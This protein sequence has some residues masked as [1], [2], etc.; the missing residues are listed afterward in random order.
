MP[1]MTSS[2][3][4]GRV[5]KDTLGGGVHRLDDTVLVDSEDAV[6]H[7]VEDGLNPRG[8]LAQ[9]IRGRLRLGHVAKDSAASHRH[10][11]VV[12]NVHRAFDGDRATIL[13]CEVDLYRADVFSGE[14][15]AEHVGAMLGRVRMDDVEDIERCDLR[16]VVSEGLAPGTVDEDDASLGSN[17][18]D[19]IARPIEEVAN[20][21]LAA[22]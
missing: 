14:K 18:H 2:D 10:A 16:L 5:P 13:G 8:T 22:A 15:P 11:L 1:D 4:V 19:E 12:A 17:T 9:M 21:R 20:P 3:F 6:G 7:R